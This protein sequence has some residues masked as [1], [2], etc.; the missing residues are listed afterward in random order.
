MTNIYEDLTAYL[1]AGKTRAQI[2][3]DVTDSSYF[4][5]LSSE[6][7]NAIEWYPF[8]KTDRV[9]EIGA[10]YGVYLPLSERVSKWDVLCENEKESLFLDTLISMGEGGLSSE[11]IGIFTEKK[12]EAYDI[13]ITD[14][15]GIERAM[16]IAKKCLIV[17]TDN[18]NALKLMT[19][20]EET[21]GKSYLS[22]EELETIKEK[23]SFKSMELYFP[24]PEADF[25]IDIRNEKDMPG[26]GSFRFVGRSI[27]EERYAI[28]NEEAIYD[29]MAAAD[30]NAV[31]LFA[32]SYVA[33]FK[34]EEN[35]A[36]PGNVAP[37]LARYNRKRN[38]KF[39]IKTEIFSD[40]V[41]KTSLS[42]EAD[43]HIE[44][45][46]RKYEL[47]NSCKDENI[48][49]IKPV[50]R[51]NENGRSEAVF[52]RLEGTDLGA[53]LTEKI[54]D[55]RAPEEEIK[56]WLNRLTP[57]GVP[58]HNLDLIFDNVFITEKGPVLI[59]Y[60]WVFEE[61]FER[62]FVRYR[63]LRYWYEDNKESL[64]AYDGLQGFL[65][66]FG[67][68]SD[69]GRFN[70]KEDEFQLLVNDI[71]L[72]DTER[73]FIR[74][75][76]SYNE[77]R[78]MKGKLDDSVNLNARL[79]D[80]IGDVKET[81]KKEREVEKLSQQHIKNIE[82]I[83]AEQKA[84]IE[85][86][87]RE[88]DYLRKH[89]SLP[90]R[91]KR[92]LVAAIDR[93]APADSKRRIGIWYAKGLLTHPS[94]YIKRFVTAEGKIRRRGD[95]EI[96]G[97]FF[98]H[99]ILN[100]PKFDN[101]SVSIVIPAYNQIGYTYACI[102]SII[103]NTDGVSYEVIL[104][105]DAS[106]D[107]TRNITDYIHN[108][109][110]AKTKGNLG[111]L[112]NCNNAAKE[113]RG[114]YVF[115]LNNDTKVTKGWL[116]NL[117]ELS[118]S[119]ESIGLVGSKLIYPDGRL[120]EAGGII[121][122]DASGWN[123][124]RLDDPGKPEYNYVK[125]VDYISGAAI[126][127]RH[128]LWN[129][130][131]GFDERYAPAY[132]E[133]SDLCFEVRRHGKRVVLDPRS[134]V[135]HFEGISNGTDT[136]GTG[137][138]RF[139]VVNQEKFKEKWKDELAKQERNTGNPDPFNARERS[140]G[141]KCILVI[142]HYVPTWDKD[143]GSKTTFQYLKLFTDKGYNVKFLGDNFLCEEPY[144][145]VLQ[146]MGIEVLYGKDL[147]VSIWDYLE[148][149][150][151]HFDFVYLNRPH[152]A[153]KYIDF[154]KEKTDCKVIYYGHDLHYLRTRREFELSGDMKKKRESDYWKS[155]E[156]QVME[157]ADCVYY[158][159]QDEIDEIAV[160]RPDIAPKCK[161]ITAYVYDDSDINNN[162]RAAAERDGL[163]FV[164]GF[165]HPPNADGVLWFVR[166]CF[167]RV[168]EALP[169]VKFRVAGSHPT[170]EI[171]SLGESDESIEILGFVSDE[172]LREL[173]RDSRL[174][175]VPLRYGAGV[176]G[177]VVEALTLNT[178]IITTSVGAEGIPEADTAMIIEDKPE[179]FAD[180]IISAYGND[181][182]IT[183]QGEKGTE[184]IRRHYCPEA[185]FDV[186]K[187]DFE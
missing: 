6:R 175:I 34:N 81:L 96:R 135:I 77:I 170:D 72:S 74:E 150:S 127:I 117:V 67:I 110:V 174:V 46:A 37:L 95:F 26:P 93:W 113:A 63:I 152:I 28:C 159:S 90:S 78:V 133:D 83:M 47:L 25:A 173:Y 186:I 134:V 98:E 71:E 91:L 182:L 176:K 75:P 100:I 109:K 23:A 52:E 18:K 136:A 143:A 179:K 151:K 120:Q 141:K 148:K 160:S 58:C 94:E 139:Q 29:K 82:K 102:R 85:A 107:E 1:K 130:I 13:V 92:R 21:A 181:E 183:A 45:F 89:E 35:G 9:L 42:A 59:D 165:K 16:G 27:L 118:E 169:G 116:S 11:K 172:R 49:I 57:D 64:T 68:S 61:P 41:I 131:G 15:F 166:E 44:S 146:R 123:Y 167:T 5:A 73:K 106:K 43:E 155:V 142:D 22:L 3:A 62:D 163:L 33:V 153:I 144:T 105:D 171:K 53:I 126:M 137:L 177:K 65:K 50:I 30:K 185:V 36:V 147:E 31:K 149:N 157:G 70:E 138:K 108:L 17:I 76:L 125:D 119:D 56:E 164:G 10:H 180:A 14:A 145:G 87:Q 40:S 39:R 54:R 103:E 128:E 124:G 104:A 121:W 140:G 162:P 60:E 122:S 38:P 24:L 111:F 4:Y 132:C 154:F 114:K 97:E 88:L 20:T 8:G 19:G 161:A 112:L 12:E 66:A 168:K 51:K 129:E 32:P 69:I 187:N 48:E 7:L 184:L 178:A 79:R 115:F 99:G 84:L 156:Y 158:P 86:G 101:I 2:L 80:E 55:K